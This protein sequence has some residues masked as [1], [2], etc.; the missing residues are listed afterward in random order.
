MRNF[1]CASSCETSTLS[2][3]AWCAHYLMSLVGMGKRIESIDRSSENSPFWARIFSHALC[4][5]TRNAQ[6]SFARCV[7]QRLATERIK[8][9]FTCVGWA[10]MISQSRVEAQRI[11]LKQTIFKTS[12]LCDFCTLVQS[13]MPRYVGCDSSSKWR[14]HWVDWKPLTELTFTSERVHEHR[15]SH[16]CNSFTY[17][18]HFA[19]QVARSCFSVYL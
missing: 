5:N 4:L 15:L 6:L 16:L 17:L 18:C 12:F 3:I 1:L 9:F 7:L 10:F 11:S 14:L 2:V 19:S 13:P 8:V